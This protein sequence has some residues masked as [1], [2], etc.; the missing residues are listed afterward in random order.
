MTE[1][2]DLLSQTQWVESFAKNFGQIAKET[3]DRK[4]RI[5]E[6]EARVIELETWKELVSKEI[7]SLYAKTGQ[8]LGGR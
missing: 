4:Q 5:K 7:Q 3:E 2:Q 1:G 8:H 6:L